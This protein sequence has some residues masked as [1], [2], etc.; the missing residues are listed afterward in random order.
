MES[1]AAAPFMGVLG[2]DARPRLPWPVR[3]AWSFSARRSAVRKPA[4]C[5]PPSPVGIVLQ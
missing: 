3:S 4:S 2:G 1:I 5:V